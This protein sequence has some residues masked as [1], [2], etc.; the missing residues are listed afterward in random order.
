MAD[1]TPPCVNH[2]PVLS[3]I[4]G[5]GC[6]ENRREE[7]ESPPSLEASQDKERDGNRVAALDPT[8]EQ[9][10]RKHTP[11]LIRTLTF[12]V[13]DREAA[14]EIAQETFI[15][16]YLHRTNVLP[17]PKVSGWIYKVALNRAR[18]HQRALA[19]AARR[20]TSLSTSLPAAE[21]VDSWRP[22]TEF[23]SLLR[24]LPMRQRTAA[25]LHYVGDLTISEVARIM[26]VSEGTVKSH[27]FR[28]HHSLKPIMEKDYE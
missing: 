25:A 9:L 14:V 24:R 23:L 19:R 18:D 2:P 17:H 27:L 5:R 20:L 3:R 11:D 13:L 8:F 7:T 6:S 12:I 16:L 22:D 21:P 26:N 10:V 28:A 1:E 4:L 15:Q